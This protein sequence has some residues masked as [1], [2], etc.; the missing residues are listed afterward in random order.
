MTPPTPFVIVP[1]VRSEHDKKPE[2][3]TTSSKSLENEESKSINN[4]VDILKGI[5]M[6]TALLPDMSKCS[7]LWVNH[8]ENR[9]KS[10]SI[11][12]DKL[13]ICF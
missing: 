13:Y 2:S 10:R 4:G 11:I 6:W 12:M 8:V 9:I 3:E 5:L 1:T 7:S